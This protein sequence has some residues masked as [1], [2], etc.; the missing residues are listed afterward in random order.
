MIIKKFQGSTE[1]EAILAARD[2]MGSSA[3]VMNIRTTKRKGL[4]GW[5][6]KDVVEVTAALEEKEDAVPA[7]VRKDLEAAPSPLLSRPMPHVEKEVFEN[8]LNSIQSLLEQQM[9]KK[10][11]EPEKPRE[12]EPEEE[13]EKESIGFLKLIYQKLI[14]NEVEEIYANQII[15]EVEK[16]LKKEA[17]L[18][19]VLSAV[20]QKIILKLGEPD[21]FD[22]G[23][24]KKKICFFIGPT[25]VGKTTTIAKLASDMKLTRK[26]N[27]ALMTADTYRIAAVEQLRTYANI[28]DIQLDV[29]YSEEE[30]KEGLERLKD[31]DMIFVDTAGRSHKNTEQC[32]ELFRLIEA[33]DE[34]GDFEKEICLVLSVTTKFRDLE[35]I[36]ETYAKLGKCRII[37]TKLDETN[38]L[39]NI[40]NVAILTNGK[41]SYTTYGQNVP[42]DIDLIDVQSIAKQLLGGV[43]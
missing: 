20:Y 34:T 31:R 6:K 18:D 19:T 35:K 25:G 13:E 9:L 17:S 10:E 16:H 26:I 12:K 22:I 36:C 4:F 42:D 7:P 3:V 29:I 40:L 15:S 39:G 33:V 41:I 8:R 30:L 2:E 5:F 43:G 27:I 32:D 11:A 1:E 38:A 23:E 28:L 37:F 24:G 21:D 14:D